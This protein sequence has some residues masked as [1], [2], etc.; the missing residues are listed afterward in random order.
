MGSPDAASPPD[1]V[2]APVADGCASEGCPPVSCGLCDGGGEFDVPAPEPPPQ[3]AAASSSA[4]TDTNA[5]IFLVM[6]LFI[7]FSSYILFY[8]SVAKPKGRP[9]S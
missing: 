3:A 4:N 2:S 5:R 7:F 1:G 9:K 8:A 6:H